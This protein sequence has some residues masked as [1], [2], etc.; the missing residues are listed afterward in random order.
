MLK[1]YRVTQRNANLYFN[2]RLGCYEQRTSRQSV[3]DWRS[4]SFIRN[5][6]RMSRLKRKFK[7]D[8]FSN[9]SHVQ[10]IQSV[11]YGLHLPEYTVRPFST[12]VKSY[13]HAQDI[14]H[15]TKTLTW[16][17]NN[18]DLSKTCN[19]NEQ[20]FSD[21]G[22]GQSFKL[23]GAHFDFALQREREWQFVAETLQRGRFSTDGE[24]AVARANAFGERFATLRD[25]AHLS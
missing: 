4:V 6:V 14:V 23:F 17:S 15:E 21:L 10:N 22:E 5:H 25:N 11:S 8:K 20:T 24:D 13:L 9:V 19:V 12:R 1:K 2:G 3:T 7:S 16:W 18:S